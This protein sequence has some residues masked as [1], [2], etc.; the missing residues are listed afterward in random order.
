M[1]RKITLACGFALALCVLIVS[2]ALPAYAAKGKTIS[3]DQL[4]GMCIAGGGHVTVPPNSALRIVGGTALIHT[5]CDITPGNNASVSIVNATIDARPGG[6][7]D[8]C[9]FPPCGTDV[10]VHVDN[11]TLYAGPPTFSS[12]LDLIAPGSSGQM[13]VKNSTINANNGPGQ[14]I[15]VYSDGTTIVDN[16]TFHASGATVIHGGVKCKSNNNTPNVPCT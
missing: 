16:T 9:F 15:L 4:P 13:L 11:S 10:K 7:F 14:S 3:A 6:D 2:A 12:G 8:I 5:E 1:V